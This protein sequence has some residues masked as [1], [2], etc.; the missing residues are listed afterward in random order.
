MS[1]IT[2]EVPDDLAEQLRP[3]HSDL[4]QILE[5]G[6][7]QFRVESDPWSAEVLGVL[8][9]LTGRPDPEQVLAYRPS[10]RMAARIR[11]LLARRRDGVLTPE[12][13]LQWQQY[14][15]LE[16]LVRMAKADARAQLPPP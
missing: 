15:F 10:D 14:E 11:E 5:L 13:Q 7:R 16:H 2:L 8:A 4:P 1:S 3:L 6:L 12:E 9:F